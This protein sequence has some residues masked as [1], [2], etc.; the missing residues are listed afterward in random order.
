MSFL[1]KIS[2]SQITEDAHDGVTEVGD[3]SAEGQPLLREQLAGAVALAVAIAVFSGLA[4]IRECYSG[5]ADLA[6]QKFAVAQ[7]E[8]FVAPSF[9][10]G[11][12]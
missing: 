7:E 12:R 6:A 11:G 8:R 1:S 5:P 3:A 10:P 9:D 4:A 2:A